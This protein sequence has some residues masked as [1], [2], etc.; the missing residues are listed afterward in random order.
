MKFGLRL[1]VAA[2][3]AIC[4]VFIMSMTKETGTRQLRQL[5]GRV[6]RHAISNNSIFLSHNHMNS[7]VVRVNSDDVIHLAFVVCGKDRVEE[8]LVMVK[9][10]VLFTRA[11]LS[12][13]VITDPELIATFNT[14]LE[15][16]KSDSGRFQYNVSKVSFP[17]DRGS[18]WRSLFKL[19]AAQ[20]LFLPEMLAEV[21]AI[22]YVDTDTLF[23]RPIDDLWNFFNLMNSSQMAAL[24]QEQ[25]DAG[26]GWYNRFARHPYYGKLGVNSGVMLMNL[27]Q[28]RQFGWTRKI[29]QYYF[30]YRHNITWGDQDLI[31][32][33]FS[34]YPEKLY[35]YP[36]EWNF[37]SDHCVYRMVCQS[38]QD[39]GASVV[40]GVRS[41]FHL[42]KHM[43]FKTVYQAMLQYKF[44]DDLERSLLDPIE[45]NLS[46][47]ANTNCG[48]VRHVFTQRLN[49]TIRQSRASKYPGS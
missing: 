7:H 3:S 1:A 30:K 48:K 26:I 42:E 5:L 29:T 21:D 11:P 8:S 6:S 40:H 9:S 32:I 14:E 13:H 23:L 31:N 39:R 18:Q 37:R 10:A 34:F 43:V 27:T 24:T 49:E 17:A 15:K 25:E 36:C 16:W 28:M 47:L 44:G 22:L 12:L 45:R 19:C 33:L 35:V 46:R 20:R 2:I 4:I 41:A 38:A